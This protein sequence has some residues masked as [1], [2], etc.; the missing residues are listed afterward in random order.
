MYLDDLR[1][2][3]SQAYALTVVISVADTGNEEGTD[4]MKVHL[5]PTGDSVTRL[6][7]PIVHLLGI[8]VKEES[9]MRLMAKSSPKRCGSSQTYH[10]SVKK[11]GHT[12]PT[13]LHGYAVEQIKISMKI[14]PTV[15]PNPTFK[16]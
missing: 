4:M 13:T 7:H 10:L 14:P 9:E 15:G 2:D 6:N 8:V 3:G 5:K 12:S 11:M 1:Q 16:F